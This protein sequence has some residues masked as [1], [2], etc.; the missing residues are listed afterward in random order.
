MTTL[1][2][3]ELDLRELAALSVLRR[4]GEPFGSSSVEANRGSPELEGPKPRAFGA[5]AVAALLRPVGAARP[6]YGHLG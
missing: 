5:S 2:L 6:P 4:V 3:A 1:C